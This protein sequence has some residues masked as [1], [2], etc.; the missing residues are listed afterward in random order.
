[1]FGERAKNRFNNVAMSM[2][3]GERF[4]LPTLSV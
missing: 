2:V 1:M 3:G 4:E